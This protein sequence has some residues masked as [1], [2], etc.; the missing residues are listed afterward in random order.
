MFTK[1]KVKM[2]DFL[3]K[4]PKTPKQEKQD[5]ETLLRNLKGITRALGGKVVEK[6][7]ITPN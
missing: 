1:K 4:K 7:K 3:P 2:E 6:Q 5:N